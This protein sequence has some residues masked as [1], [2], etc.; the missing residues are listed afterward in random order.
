MAEIRKYAKKLCITGITKTSEVDPYWK[1]FTQLW[2]QIQKACGS[3]QRKPRAIY[4]S[5]E[6]QRVYGNDY[7]LARRILVDLD[8]NE[9]LDSVYVS[10]GE[11]AIN[12]G[13]MDREVS[14]LPKNI[15]LLDCNWSDYYR[16]F[17]IHAQFP[18]GSLESSLL[19]G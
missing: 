15:A 8:K 6:P 7:D 5:E 10:T 4:L 14:G 16:S 11:C 17:T 18:V 19:G 2:P 9:V 3:K 1:N 12:N 13:G